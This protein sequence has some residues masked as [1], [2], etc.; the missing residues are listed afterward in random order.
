[1]R[2]RFARQ[3]LSDWR[4]VVE[5]VGFDERKCDLLFVVEIEEPGRD[6]PRQMRFV[7]AGREKKGCFGAELRNALTF[8]TTWTSAALVDPVVWKRSPIEVSIYGRNTLD[9]GEVENPISAGGH[10][11]RAP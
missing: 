1:M 11:A 3:A 8:V 4:D 6:V 2:G 10:R 7:D 5:I 9:I